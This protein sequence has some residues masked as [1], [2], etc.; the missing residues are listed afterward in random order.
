[1]AMK[2]EEDVEAKTVETLQ[3]R[4]MRYPLLPL[5]LLPLLLLLVILLLV[6]VVFSYPLHYV[7]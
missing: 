4:L 5:L 3:R 1:M 6:F 7:M 2:I